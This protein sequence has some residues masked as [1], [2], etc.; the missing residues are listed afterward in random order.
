M[1]QSAA[2]WPIFSSEL[3]SN[4]AANRLPFAQAISPATLSPARYTD[5][6]AIHSGVSIMRKRAAILFALATL[7]ASSAG[8]GTTPPTPMPAAVEA[9]PELQVPSVDYRKEWVQL[10][11]YAVL[12]DTPADGAKKLQYVYTE[13]KNL[14]AYLKSGSFPDGTVLVKDVYAGKIETLTC[15]TVSYAGDLVGRFILFRDSSSARTASSPRFGDGWGWA[16]YDGSETKMTVTT[17]YKTDCLGCHSPAR[18]TDM[19]YVQ[20]YPLLRK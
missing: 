3:A 8:A 1:T 7:V 12:A 11:T 9:E 17:N 4:T 10:G 20:G 6:G 19:L 16:Y 18:A 5:N 15:G 13:R 2:L 14:E